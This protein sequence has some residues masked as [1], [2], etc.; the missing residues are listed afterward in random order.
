[1]LLRNIFQR[2]LVGQA[3][4]FRGLS[5]GRPTVAALLFL[6]ATSALAQVNSFPRPSYFRETFAHPATH[7]ELAGPVR[8][9]DF[10]V[11]GKDGK[12]LELSLKDYLSLVMSNNTDIAI[13]R[14]TVYTAEDAIMR[15][16][17]AFD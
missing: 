15:S 9:E 14:L 2:I 6:I 8:L 10:V 13:Q 12:V 4:A 17:S 1:M 7:V 11:S 16:F 5:T 3:I